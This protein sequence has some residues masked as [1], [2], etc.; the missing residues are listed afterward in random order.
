M[1]NTGITPPAC[2]QQPSANASTRMRPLIRQLPSDPG[3]SPNHP[4]EDRQ[5]RFENVYP[6]LLLSTLVYFLSSRFCPDP[7][8]ME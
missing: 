1:T 5:A 4:P 7:Y 2:T 6:C 3:Q 8:P